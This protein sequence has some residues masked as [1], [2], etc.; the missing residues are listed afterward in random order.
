VA[1]DAGSNRFSGELRV[2]LH[3]SGLTL[4]AVQRRLSERGFAIGRST[5]SYWQNGHRLPTQPTSLLAV[6]ALEEIL[7][8]PAGSFTDALRHPSTGPATADLD[9]ATTADRIGVLMDGVGCPEG[10]TTLEPLS[11]IQIA[12]YGATGCLRSVRSIETYRAL[13]D[14]ER[15]PV[16]FGGEPGGNPDLMRLE[17]VSGG[18]I[19]RVRRDPEV[20]VMVSELVFDRQVRRG[21]HHFLHYLTFDDNEQRSLLLYRLVVT[22]R[23]MMVL[24]LGFHPDCLPVRLEEYERATDSSPDLFVRQR[25]LSPDRRVTLVRERARRGIVGLRWEY[26]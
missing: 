26:A 11:T 9:M 19:G 13:A 18:R 8:V 4:D 17:A 16:L 20:N 25:T 2:A 22:S 5:L 21:E 23:S 6:A 14:T 1:V 3:A 15:F 24:D 7:K 12:E 10:V